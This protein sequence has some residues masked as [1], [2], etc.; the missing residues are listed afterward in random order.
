MET[1][2]GIA[3]RAMEEDEDKRQVAL[4]I[5]IQAGV[6][7]ECEFHPGTYI[8]GDEEIESA[9]KLANSSYSNGEYR[10]MFKSR[11]DLTDAI[12]D[13]V[14]DNAG[15]CYSCEKWKSD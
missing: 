9:Y 13:V 6:L 8:E 10:G 11:V 7:K 2:M 15:E 5:A 12:K 3:K 1:N 4:N 14:S